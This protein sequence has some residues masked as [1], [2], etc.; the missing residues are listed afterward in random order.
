MP[1][2]C[3]RCSNHTLECKCKKECIGFFGKLFGHTFTR[4]LV[5]E[6]YKQ[7]PAVTYDVHGLENVKAFMES[8]RDIYVVRCKRC[9][10]KAE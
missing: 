2:E 3:D 4:Y 10:S 6:K 7:N 5:K 9:G 8:Q 1:G